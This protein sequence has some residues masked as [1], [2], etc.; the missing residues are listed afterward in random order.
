MTL[1]LKARALKLLAGREHTRQELSAKLAP[2]T[3]TPAELA[4]LLDELERRYPALRANE[5]R[6][7]GACSYLQSSGLP[8]SPRSVAK[9][10]SAGRPTP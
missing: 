2:H 1:S 9:K 3:E 7:P 8:S 5:T 4:P 6:S 10:T